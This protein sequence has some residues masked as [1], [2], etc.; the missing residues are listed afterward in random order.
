MASTARGPA[1][2]TWR[3]DQTVIG[4]ARRQR[5]MISTV[6]S[7]PVFFALGIGLLLTLTTLAGCLGTADETPQYQGWI[8]GHFVF[9]GPD[10]TGRIETLAVREGNTVKKGSALFTLDSELQRDAV[11]E[12]KAALGNAQVAYERAKDLLTKKVGS[13]KTFDDAEAA[14]RAAQ[15]H[16]NT[17]VTRLTRRQVSS[18]VAGVVQEVYFRVGEMVQAAR[19]IVSILPPGDIR[20][21]F[22]VPQ[23]VVPKLR[24]GGTVLIKCDGCEKDLRATISFISDKAEFT[25]PVI[26]SPKERA[27]LVFRIEARPTEP[28]KVRVGQPVSIIPIPQG[29][30]HNGNAG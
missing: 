29:A 5:A 19:P 9:V 10:E 1:A 20:A 18:P 12:A 30:G 23:A 11:A 28:T 25:P 13:A 2:R 17:A 16:L 7:R 4:N 6:K 3:S 21:R 22:F 14:L 24:I 27:R 8:E 15:A 26:Y